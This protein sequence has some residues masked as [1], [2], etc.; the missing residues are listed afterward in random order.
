MDIYDRRYRHEYK[1]PISDAEIHLAKCR[2]KGLMSIDSH[3]DEYGIYTI[4]SL[5]FDDIY[6]TCYRENEDGTDPR[7]K[8]RIRIYNGNV[9]RISLECKRKEHGKTLKTSCPLTYE[10]AIVLC[11]GGKLQVHNEQNPLL[12]RMILQMMARG[13]KPR[14]IV[15]YDRIPYVYP[16]GNVRVTFDMNLASSSDTEHFLTGASKFRPVMPVGINLLEVKFDE[17]IP[18]CVF[19]SLQ[20]DNLTRMSFSKYFLCRKFSI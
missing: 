8:F 19:N 12:N 17:L 16:V 14:I 18:D 5:Y 13:L 10:Q 20:L 4:S 2:L 7:E 9:S 6:D 11:C 3:A 1:Y 15:R